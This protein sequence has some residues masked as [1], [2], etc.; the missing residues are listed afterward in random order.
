MEALFRSDT[1]FRGILEAVDELDLPSRVKMDHGGRLQ[2]I[3]S[4]I[5]NVEA[6]VV[7]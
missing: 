3:G 1:V 7:Q 4:N 2:L 6:G 5:Q